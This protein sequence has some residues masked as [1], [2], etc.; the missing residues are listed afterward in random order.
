VT[1]S[2]Y[3]LVLADDH[4]IVREGLRLLLSAVPGVE[5]VGEAADGR[6][7]VQIAVKLQPDLLVTDLSMPGISGMAS[8]REIKRRCAHTRVLVLTVHRDYEYVSASLSAGADG[9]VLKDAG[10]D[11]LISAV[12]SVLNGKAY[13]S[14]D[15]AG[16]I[17][18]GF[19]LGHPSSTGPA[20]MLG[21]LT[22]R[23]RDV[24]KLVAEGRTNKEA[25]GYL[26][27]SVKTVEKHRA[28]LKHKLGIHRTAELVSFAVESGV[29]RR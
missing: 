13:L 14:P 4:T 11:E 20:S 26:C 21:K 1:H 19:V 25:A 23:E 8:I 9:Y 28:N 27:V 6:S 3:R 7:A 29:L 5:V 18:E 16:Q 2:T 17:V 24:L 15:V 12:N 10:R 22:D